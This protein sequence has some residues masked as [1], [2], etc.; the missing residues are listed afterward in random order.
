MAGDYNA[1]AHLWDNNENPRGKKLQDWH[2][3]K[4]NKFK[5]LNNEDEHSTIHYSTPHLTF[6]SNALNNDCTWRVNYDIRSDIHYGIK[7]T[8]GLQNYYKEADSVPRY[9]LDEADWERFSTALDNTMQD[10]DVA[11]INALPANDIATLINDQFIKAADE[12]IDETKYCKTPWRCWYWNDECTKYK[13]L[14]RQ[15]LTKFNDKRYPRRETRPIYKAAK[16]VWIETMEKAKREAWERI[17]KE[18]Q[19]ENNDDKTWRKLKY[20]RGQPSPHRHPDPQA[21]AELLAT[22]FAGRTS[23]DNLPD[24]VLNELNNL[25]PIRE[26][27][28]AN[29][30][31]QPDLTHDQEFTIHE[32]NRVLQVNEKSAPGSDGMRRS[33]LHHTGPGARQILLAFINRL[34]KDRRLPGSWKQAEQVP[35]PKPDKCNA[36]RPISLLS[37]VSKTMESMVLNR[38]LTIAR[39][40]F[41]DLL[42]GFLPHKGTTDGLVTLASANN[43]HIGTGTGKNKECITR[44]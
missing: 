13:H 20:I 4:N 43:E 26:H 9:K 37:C 40:Q 23:R 14:N 33:M 28:V 11:S 8:I 39:P 36:F 18:I 7:I 25:A 12:S 2:Y 38:A 27:I 17:V 10:F 6:V 30:L 21:Q 19:L 5:L 35:I 31:E 15:A 29:A 42:Y 22:E 32:L 3:G 1:R 34:Y 16:A 24:T 41:S 44:H